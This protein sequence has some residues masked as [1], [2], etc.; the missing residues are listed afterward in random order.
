MSQPTP[1][2][3]PE[4]TKETYMN[5]RT[6]VSLGRRTVTVGGFALLFP[7]S[8]LAA[9]NAP[10]DTLNVKVYSDHYV[11]A[12]KPFADLAA[13]KAWAEPILIHTVWL[14]FCGSVS[15][16]QLIGLVARFHAAYP[17][18]IQIRTLS[19]GDARCIPAAGHASRTAAEEDLVPADAEYLAHDELG[20]SR[21]P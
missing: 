14:D 10:P 3:L 17:A 7:L 15:T 5:T 20:R 11:A 19:P 12:G 6:L 13:L 1:A 8:G 4:S 21:L 2:R 16:E 9:D 18:G